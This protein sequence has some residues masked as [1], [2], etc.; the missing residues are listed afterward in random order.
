MS[1]I[2]KDINE[3]E[4]IDELDENESLNNQRP[5]SPDIIIQL[6]NKYNNMQENENVKDKE[7][8]INFDDDI[9]Q[10]E[11]ESIHS[12]Y[13]DSNNNTSRKKYQK[14]DT[15]IEIYKRHFKVIIRNIP[16]IYK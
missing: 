12:S 16:K 15:E 9:S 3:D 8:I 4:E 5:Q 13:S 1:K 7:D 14:S 2:D 11:N 10:S 6:I